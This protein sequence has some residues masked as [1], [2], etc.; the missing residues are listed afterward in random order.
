MK[1][2]EVNVYP[3]THSPRLFKNKFL[4]FLTKTHPIVI[5]GM[6]L[7]LSCLSIAYFSNNSNY[8]IGFIIGLF[9]GGFFFWSLAEYLLHRFLYHKI[10]DATFNSGIQYL[11]HGI[12]HEY[13]NDKT[14]LVLPV[15]P[16]LAFAS[17]FFGMF[18]LLMGKY[19]FVF[20]PG[21]VIGYCAYMTVHYAIHK[22]TPP[23]RFNFWWKFHNI[24]HFQQHDRAFG[25]TSP[26]WDIIFRTMPEK[27]RRTVDIKKKSTQ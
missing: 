1:K 5:D 4:E 26:L 7:A 9:F 23:K 10:E 13:P 18:Y 16:S 19:V 24:H 14:R 3:E 2:I 15:I 12:H 17:F 21:F 25:V 20:L 11:F 22:L 6:Y 27:N 8:S